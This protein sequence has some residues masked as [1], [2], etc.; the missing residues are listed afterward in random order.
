MTGI[1]SAGASVVKISAL[2]V[3]WPLVCLTNLFA[4]DVLGN[5]GPRN[6]SGTLAPPLYCLFDI[7]SQP[8]KQLASFLCGFMALSA[9]SCLKT[10]ICTCGSGLF[11]CT[12]PC[13]DDLLRID[14]YYKDS[15]NESLN[16]GSDPD[17]IPCGISQISCG[18]RGKCLGFSSNHSTA[19][20]SAW[21][22]LE[23]SQEL[24]ATEIASAPQP[25]TRPQNFRVPRGLTLSQS[26]VAVDGWLTAPNKHVYALQPLKWQWR[27]DSTKDGRKIRREKHVIESCNPAV[28]FADDRKKLLGREREGR[29]RSCCAWCNKFVLS[30]IEKAVQRDGQRSWKDQHCKALTTLCARICQG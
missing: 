21:K 15:W 22:D 1:S 20:W 29:Q 25:I 9:N 11:L 26:L 8:R 13:F 30:N 7:S 2:Y 4:T 18:R 5:P 24:P 14:M 19:E 17:S 10:D 23:T 16:P 12:R 27:Q 28:V 6:T 3:A